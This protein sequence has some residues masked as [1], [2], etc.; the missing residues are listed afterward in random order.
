MVCYMDFF[1]PALWEAIST[2]SKLRRIR[3]HKSIARG[4]DMD[5]IVDAIKLVRVF[6]ITHADIDFSGVTSPLTSTS[7]PRLPNLQSLDIF[8]PEN[9]SGNIG[10][11]IQHAPRLVS[12]KM[13]PQIETKPAS[14]MRELAVSLRGCRK[15]QDITLN[16]MVLSNEDSNMIFSAV[17]D[18]KRLSWKVGGFS[19]QALGSLISRHSRTITHLYLGDSSELTSSMTQTIMANCPLLEYLRLNTISGTDLAR[20]EKVDQGNQSMGENTGQVILGEDWICL[21]IKTLQLQFDLSSKT[22]DIDRNTPE[23]EAMFQCQQQLEQYHVFRQI[24][25]LTRLQDLFISKSRFNRENE[26]SLDL[27]LEA[28]GGS[29]EG[30]TALKELQSIEFYDTN[31]ELGRDEIDWMLSQLPCLKYLK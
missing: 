2:C 24:G 14:H 30:L 22:M 26:R 29:L 11:L 7:P 17:T 16:N 9:F 6:H 18:T 25:R 20:I 8:R 10:P 1:A 23:G 27:R 21:G 19:W 31:Q 3:L 28:N 5:K 13:D 4:P 12:L 15:L